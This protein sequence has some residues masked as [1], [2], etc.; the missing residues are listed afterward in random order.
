M[1]PGRG[2]SEQSGNESNCEDRDMYYSES[3]GVSTGNVHVTS[4]VRELSAAHFKFCVCPLCRP[5][6]LMVLPPH[7][8]STRNLPVYRADGERTEDGEGE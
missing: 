1:S 8:S 7:G 6:Y 5:S 3:S 2:L 4:V